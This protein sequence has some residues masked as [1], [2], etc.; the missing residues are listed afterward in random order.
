MAPGDN[1]PH[2]EGLTM[3][4]YTVGADAL[5]RPRVLSELVAPK[6][7]AAVRAAVLVA[8]GAGFVGLLAQLSIKL[9]NTPVPVTGQTFGVL[10]VGA[11]LGWQQAALSMGL[12]L[13]AGG[14]GVPWFANAGHGWGGPSFGYVIG[15]LVAATVVGFLASR[16]GDRTVVRTVA[17]MVVGTLIIYAIGVPWLAHQIH[18]PFTKAW[19]LGARPFFVGDAIKIG[20]AAGVLPGAWALVRKVRD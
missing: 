17:T 14:L 19:H 5:S 9:P 20:L 15:F 2:P 4:S 16:G 8:A 18:V 1:R 3:T 10:L 11:V 13:V 6:L 12:Y 7:P